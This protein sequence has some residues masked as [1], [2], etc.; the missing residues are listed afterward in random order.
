MDR[1][2][3]FYIMTTEEI[4][5]IKT[6]TQFTSKFK[7]VWLNKYGKWGATFETKGYKLNLGKFETEEK[8]AQ[9]YLH[10]Y[11]E[12]YQGILNKLKKEES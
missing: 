11:E 10:E 1:S 3:I 6:V 12:Y 7:G 2:P 9:A 8:A 4:K 5:A